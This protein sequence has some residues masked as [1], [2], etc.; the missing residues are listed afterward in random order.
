[1]IRAIFFVV[2]IGAG[3]L[4]AC[5]SDDSHGAALDATADT[6]LQD[7]TQHFEAASDSARGSEGGADV[8]LP[9]ASSTD[10]FAP[11][12]S[13]PA[14]ASNDLIV[15]GDVDGGDADV[16]ET[17]DASDADAA[18]G[19]AGC[20]AN[21]LCV[22]YTSNGPACLPSCSLDGGGCT[23]GAVCTVTSGCC[24][25]TGCSAVAVRVCC[26]ASGC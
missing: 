9:D 25:G 18:D 22:Q 26:P 12:V 1:M 15:N 16:Q 14:D 19:S 2:A 6:I 4:A 13:P 23:G 24:Q 5:S 8:S 17:A 7:V 11:D 21:E 3:A 20:P 10:V